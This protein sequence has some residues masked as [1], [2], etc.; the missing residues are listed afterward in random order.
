MANRE[1]L[2]GNEGN[3]GSSAPKSADKR[4]QACYFPAGMVEEISAQAARL[5]SILLLGGPEGVE[6][7]KER[8]CRHARSGWHGNRQRVTV[9]APLPTC[10]LLPQEVW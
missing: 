6:D 4:K 7:G 8:H 10:Y 2:G 3:V 1:R 9:N 5:D